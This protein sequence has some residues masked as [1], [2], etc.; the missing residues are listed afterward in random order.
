M[1][2]KNIK[3]EIRRFFSI[4]PTSRLRVRQ[5][6]RELNLPLPSVIRYCKEL[7]KENILKKE[8]ISNIYL[9]SADRSSKSYLFEKRLF[10]VKL[11]FESGL[12]DHLIKEYSNPTIL[13][14]G[15]YSKGE[16]IEK[17]DIDL[18]VETP[19]KHDFN[20]Q[21][22]EKILNRRIQIFNYKNINDITNPHLSNNIVN[23]IILNGFLEVFK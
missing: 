23:G 2:R 19:K 7:E 14:F 1:K 10:N 5:M 20:L 17:S 15:S 11:L 18:Y 16:D 3:E 4:Y 9:Y 21:K 13:L 6:E 22:F 8:K 12:V